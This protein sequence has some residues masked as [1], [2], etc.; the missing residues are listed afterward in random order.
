MRS[1]SKRLKSFLSYDKL[2]S[3]SPMEMASAGFYF[4]GTE[5][6]VQCFCCGLVFCATSVRTSPY[7]NHCKNNPTC[8][9]IQGKDIG[10]IPKYD[11]RVQSITKVQMNLQDYELEES[12]LN[13]FSYWPFYARIQPAVLAC[14]GFYFTGRKDTVQCFSCAG[15]LGNWE[16]N[17][18]PWREHAKWFP[19]CRFLS[20][21]KTPD[22]INQYITSYNGFSGFTC[23]IKHSVPKKRIVVKPM[24]SS[25]L[26]S[27]CQVDLIDLQSY[28]DGEYQFI[29]VYQDHLTKFVQ[30][31]PLKTKRAEEVAYH[32]LSIF[33][34][35]GAPAILQSDNG[36]E[37]SNQV[38]SEI[39]AMWKDNTTYHEGIRQ[40]PYE[41]MFGIKAKRGIAS[42]FL[43]SE[44]IANIKTE[45]QL[46]EIA[47]TFET[48]EQLEETVNTSEKNLSGGHTEN[49]IPKKNIEEDLQSPTSSHQVLTEKHKF[50]SIK[51]AAAKEN[52]L[53]Q[54]TKMLRTSQKRFPPAQIGD[55]VRIQV[56]DVDRGRGTSMSIFVDELVRLES[57]KEW[58]PNAHADPAALARCGFYYTGVSDAVK[59]FTCGIHVHLFEPEDDPYFEHQKHS[60]TCEFL[61]KLANMKHKEM[62]NDGAVNS[63]QLVEEKK[64]GHDGNMNYARHLIH[65][66]VICKTYNPAKTVTSSLGHVPPP[67]R[68]LQDLVMDFNDRDKNIIDM[69]LLSSVGTLSGLMPFPAE[70]LMFEKCFLDLGYA[71]FNGIVERTNGILKTKLAKRC[72]QTSLDCLNEHWCQDATNLRLLTYAYNDSNFSKIYSFDDSSHVSIDL[73][74]LF[75]DISMVMKD[76]RNQPLQN[77]PF[78]DFLSDLR[79]ITMIEGEA[80][81]GKTALLKKIAILWA[82]GCCP[83]LSRFS[84]VFYVSVSTI[85]RQQSVA[86]I[87]CKQLIGHTISL[88]DETLADIIKQLKNQVLFLVDDYGLVD[89]IPKPIEELLLKNHL[90]R[91]NLA[92]TVRTD[93]GRKLRQYARSILS[94][95]EFP[96]YSSIYICRQL[97]SHDLLLIESF[98]IEMVYSMT[99]QAI[100]KTPLFTFALC[101]FLVQNPYNYIASD[102]LI[103]KAY[104]M[105]NML[106]HSKETE[107]INS[108]VSSCG[109]LALNGLLQSHFDFAEEDLC[110]SGVNSDDALKFGLLSKFT[111]QKLHPIY[112]F[113]HPSFQEFLA[114]KKLGELLESVDKAPRDKGFSYLEEINTFFKVAG[115]F[116]YFLQ[117]VCMHSQEVTT[118]IISHLFELLNNN[119]AFV[120]QVDTKVHLQH[121]PELACIEEMLT[122]QSNN[123]PSS[124]VSIVINMLL[125]FVLKAVYSNESTTECAPV[126][127]KFIKGKKITMD[128]LSPGMSVFT[129]IMEYPE[130]LSLI[131]SIELFISDIQRKSNVLPLYKN[132]VPVVDQDYSMAFPQVSDSGANLK[133]DDYYPQKMIDLSM[134]DFNKGCHK[135]AVLKV[136][137]SGNITEL[138]KSLGN[139]MVF[140]SLSD[141]IELYLNKSP[142]FVEIVR[143]CIERYKDS[144]VKCII[145]D[146][147]L[148]IEE[149][150]LIT[151]MSSLESLEIIKLQSADH[152][153]SHMDKFTR[154]KELTLILSDHTEVVGKLPDGFRHFHSL[155]KLTISDLNLRNHS[156]KLAEF[157]ASFPNLTSLYLTFDCCPEFKKIMAAISHHG[158]IQNLCVQGCYIEKM[159]IISLVSTLPALQ[160]LKNLDL[161]RQYFEDVEAAEMLAQALSSLVQ[162]EELKLPSGPAVKDTAVTIMD[163][164]QYLLHLRVLYFANNTLDNC[165]LLE[166]AKAARAGNLRNLQN[167]NLSA[168]YDITQSGWRDFFQTLDDLPN[169][170]ELNILRLYTQQFKTE[171]L[172]LIALVQCVSRMPSIN[173]LIMFGWLLDT[174]DLEMFNAMKE[175]HPQ[176]KSLMLLWQWA[177]PAPAIVQ[178]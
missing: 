62:Q 144:F 163:Q 125:E 146:V 120:C 170:K 61:H 35:F 68:L 118:I 110:A 130:V 113:C 97:F 8:G 100:L 11:V 116:H 9:F 33:L 131:G 14:A 49:H 112:R 133:E 139:L 75:A 129:F 67:M 36:R 83:I 176:A 54:A 15:C 123:E 166:L 90:N 175:R 32:V 69:F 31:R 121:H 164:F 3:W 154:L 26:N 94:I 4:T 143:P 156:S 158:K 115:R 58:P 171:A 60:P 161:R 57:F 89:P 132:V 28:R 148:S 29:M 56:P 19:E 59:C 134:I 165:S 167:L 93:K 63:V 70:M 124:Y 109:E 34:T 81:S 74:S 23:Q 47:N 157:I 102:I 105:H 6:S 92:V 87:I 142:G 162:L 72:S 127:L 66:C 140:L 103:C 104:L 153:L 159:E 114:A 149:Q 10:N 152:L 71:Q 77:L 48:E 95:Q 22:E 84:L 2:S 18:D 88:T 39:Y 40:S 178:E 138:E 46:E 160:N 106:K 5:R 137:A 107:S 99:I 51:R 141:H 86:D 135:L 117:Y 91:V 101:V 1:E 169:L 41:A 155:E 53:L 111:S 50:I 151:Q 37:F 119:E 17:D 42:S 82:S 43:P 177:L 136:E 76:T 16:E 150:E 64:E 7:E 13:S 128:L 27:R 122:V 174:K 85:E 168:N 25:E 73:K 20:N 126:I 12:R 145:H 65:H 24:V 45:E 55:T 173:Q 38:I 96:L 78:P 21:M 147:E 44:Q 30:L 98:L 80:G 172:T 79:D 52:L 108:V